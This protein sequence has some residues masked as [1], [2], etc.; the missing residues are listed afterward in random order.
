MP[1]GQDGSPFVAGNEG[2]SHPVPTPVCDFVRS[3]AASNPARL[4]MPG[5]KGAGILGFEQMDITEIDGAGELYASEGILADSEAVASERFGCPTFY[6]AEGSSLALRAMLCLALFGRDARR[7]DRPRVLAGRNAHRVFLSGAALLDFDVS[8]L[9]PLPEDAYCACTVT[10]E[11]VAGAL[12]AAP[13]PFDAVYVTSPDYLGHVLDIEGIARACH[14]R[15]VPLLVDGAHGAYLRFLSPS[16]HPMDLGADVC[17]ASAHKTLP[18]VTG[19]AYLHVRDGRLAARA[20]DALSLFGSTSPSWLILQS[21]DAL[22][23]ILATLPARLHA[24]LPEI[25]ALKARLIAHG[26]LFTGDEPMKLTLDARAAGMDGNDLAARLLDAGVACEF[27]DAD[28]VTLMPSP[29]NGE[30]DLARLE[31]ALS[32]VTPGLARRDRAPAFAMPPQRMRVREAMFAPRITLPAAQCEGRI[33][34]QPSASCP[35]A[36]PIVMPGEEIDRATVERLLYYGIERCDVVR[37]D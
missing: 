12:D 25:E 16:R 32:A 8:W 21:L 4:H 1:A 6:S 26:Y 14:A 7:Q 22:N 36:V 23:P 17:C 3:Y 15:G 30:G 2:A 29:W 27:H 18:A 33:L 19:A 31:A 28:F 9:S 10:P 24:F 13:V 35:P 11:A 5:H 37:E 20:R 34:A